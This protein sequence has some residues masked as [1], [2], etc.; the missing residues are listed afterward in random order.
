[1]MFVL[2][3]PLNVNV[4]VILWLPSDPKCKDYDTS[5]PLYVIGCTPAGDC[6]IVQIAICRVCCT[7]RNSEEAVV[8][9][10]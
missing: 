8:S 6:C 3:V 10:S 7:R 1:M 4:V 2:T 9:E 5:S